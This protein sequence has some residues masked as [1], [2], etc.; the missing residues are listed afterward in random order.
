MDHLLCKFMTRPPIQHITYCFRPLKNIS[1]S[2]FLTVSHRLTGLTVAQAD[3]SQLLQCDDTGTIYPA[4]GFKSLP[5]RPSPGFRLSI[6]PLRL[7]FSSAAKA[8]G[9][10]CRSRGTRKKK[11]SSVTTCRPKLQAILFSTWSIDGVVVVRGPPARHSRFA[12]H[13]P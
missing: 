13:W 11:D 2:R 7:L 4:A 1:S 3:L 9:A 6:Y 5:P 12:F 10:T 8:L